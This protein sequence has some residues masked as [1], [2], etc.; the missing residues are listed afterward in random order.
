MGVFRPL[1]QR[2]SKLVVLACIAIVATVATAEGVRWSRAARHHAKPDPVSTAAPVPVTLTELSRAIIPMPKGVPSAHA[3]ALA[4]LPHGDLI[5]FWWAGSRESGPDVQVYASRWSN[6]RWSDNWVVASRESLGAALGHGVRRIG[7]PVAW[8][9]DDGTIHLYVVATGLG[10]WAASR[11]VQLQSTDEGATFK[12]RRVLPMSPVFNTS[13]LVRSS[14][15]GLDGG[16]WWLPV[17]FEIGH[18]YPM[19]VTFD[20]NGDPQRLTRIGERTRSLQPTLVPVSNTEIRA[21]MRDANK[22]RSMVQQ[23]VSHD[24]GVTWE[25][26]GPTSISNLGTSLAVLRL[27]SGSLLMLRNNGTNSETARSTLS[28]SQS[29]DGH[30]WKDMTDIVSGQPGDEFSYPAMYQLGDELHITYTYQRRAIA[31]HRL[32]IQ[33]VKDLP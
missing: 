24:S 7:N 14:P 15:V 12:V 20:A 27:D 28:L 17:Y 23:A 16:G 8:T 2:P 30:R 11:V 19:L 21:W 33:P 1:L 6:G 10:G 26:M 32:K 18:K 9:G 25:D 13:V 31:H 4:E 29:L 22:S 3:S 5:S